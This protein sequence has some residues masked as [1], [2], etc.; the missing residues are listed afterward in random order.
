M[1]TIHVS[2]TLALSVLKIEQVNYRYVKVHS[3]SIALCCVTLPMYQL[4]SVASHHSITAISVD[5]VLQHNTVA[6]Y[7]DWTFVPR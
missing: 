6:A 7:D 1:V 5:A 3:Y 4:L 2:H